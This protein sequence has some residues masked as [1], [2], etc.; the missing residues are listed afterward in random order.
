MAIQAELSG[1]NLRIAGILKVLGGTHTR[2]N[3]R[4]SGFFG[5][6]VMAN[7]LHN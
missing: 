4:S 6:A 1:R 7:H 2:S 3:Q 5:S